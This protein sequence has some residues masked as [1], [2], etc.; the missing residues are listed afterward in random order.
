MFFWSKWNIWACITHIGVHGSAEMLWLWF[1]DLGDHSEACA[2]RM[3]ERGC[4]PV[5]SFCFFFFPFKYV[6]KY[7]SSVL[8]SFS[9]MELAGWGGRSY[10]EA[11]YLT[12]LTHL[13][14]FEEQQ[15]CFLHCWK[16]SVSLLCWSELHHGWYL[17]SS[18]EEMCGT[19]AGICV[20][21]CKTSLL[22]EVH[23]HF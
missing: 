17:H 10:S 4:L 18:S 16:Y 19:F 22:T 3:A 5:S 21:L 14:R 23:R 8:F 2:V 6:F 13:L 1:D 11:F 15:I 12:P 7:F 20:K 9:Y